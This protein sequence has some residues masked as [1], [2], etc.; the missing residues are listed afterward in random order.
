MKKSVI[1]IAILII[2]VIAVISNMDKGETNMDAKVVLL[3]TTDWLL[4]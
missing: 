4:S 1:I 2:G 3:E